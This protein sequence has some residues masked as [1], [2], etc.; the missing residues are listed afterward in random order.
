MRHTRVAKRRPGPASWP[1]RG[2]GGGAGARGGNRPGTPNVI[3]GGHAGADGARRPGRALACR[4][5][6]SSS[7]QLGLR[8]LAWGAAGALIVIRRFRWNPGRNN[9]ADRGAGPCRLRR[10]IR[11]AAPEVRNVP[12]P[13]PVPAG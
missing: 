8:L 1:P 2:P 7:Q 3:G 11:N 10:T 5:A 6:A 13:A 9:P 12:T 4:A